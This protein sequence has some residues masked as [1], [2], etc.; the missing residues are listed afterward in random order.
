MR[1]PSVCTRVSGVEVAI[2]D[3]KTGFIVPIRNPKGLAK[4]INTILS[5]P[6]L[7][8]EMGNNARERVV[9]LFDENKLIDRQIQI[10][11]DF[12]RKNKEMHFS[13]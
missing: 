6:T 8:H 2:E 11:E 12:F 1:K 5:N 10:Y 4:A 9:N 13:I 7:A 3:G